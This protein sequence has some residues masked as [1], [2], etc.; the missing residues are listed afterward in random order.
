MVEEVKKPYDGHKV[1][2]S[3]LS[4]L[5]APRTYMPAVT[6]LLQ[7]NYNTELLVKGKAREK[8]G[9]KPEVKVFSFPYSMIFPGHVGMYH[10]N[11]PNLFVTQAAERT[12]TKW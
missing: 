3:E 6:E 11:N 12:F 1:C 5:L 10:V 7:L 4:C 8:N 2:V 9:Q